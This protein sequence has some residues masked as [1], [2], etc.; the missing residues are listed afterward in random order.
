MNLLKKLSLELRSNDIASGSEEGGD[1]NFIKSML[2]NLQNLENLELGVA[3]CGLSKEYIS[4]VV[5]G[6]QGVQNLKNV[7]LVA[8]EYENEKSEGLLEELRLKL[9]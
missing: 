3:K 8:Y 4:G 6:I 9:D 7:K 1:G 5:Q 2:K